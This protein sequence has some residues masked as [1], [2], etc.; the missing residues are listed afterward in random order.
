MEKIEKKSNRP[1]SYDMEWDANGDS[2]LHDADAILPSAD[3]L[4]QWLSSVK[5]SSGQ[6]S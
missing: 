3:Q 1:S 6:G 4:N 2:L 5:I